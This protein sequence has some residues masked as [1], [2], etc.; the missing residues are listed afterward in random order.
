MNPPRPRPLPSPI[1]C[2]ATP[3]R[4]VWASLL[5]IL[6]CLVTT[7]VAR[8][9]QTGWEP[10]GSDGGIRYMIQL[11]ASQIELWARTGQLDCRIDPAVAGRVSE[12]QLLS[13]P[14]RAGQALPRQTPPGAM[15]R[16]LDGED[17][18]DRLSLKPP[19]AFNFPASGLDPASGQNGQATTTLGSAFN[20][21]GHQAAAAAAGQVD[22]AG[23]QLAGQVNQ[24]ISNAAGAASRSLYDPGT[25]VPP[26]A[27][28]TPAA[29]LTPGTAA[30]GFTPPRPSTD[31]AVGGGF[32]NDPQSRLAASTARP[33]TETRFPEEASATQGNGG[34]PPLGGFGVPLPGFDNPVTP[35]SSPPPATSRDFSDASDFASRQRYESGLSSATGRDAATPQDSNLTADEAAR[36]PPRGFSYDKYGWPIDRERFRLDRDGYRLDAD[37]QRLAQNDPRFVQPPRGAGYQPPPSRPD[38]SVD[39]RSDRSPQWPTEDDGRQDRRDEGRKYAARGYDDRGFDDRGYDD[40]VYEDRNYDDRGY[41]DREYDDRRRDDRGYDRRR[42]ERRYASAEPNY[43]SAADRLVD[44]RPQTPLLP[45]GSVGY[46]R[47]AGAG[48]VDYVNAGQPLPAARPPLIAAGSAAAPPPPT[49]TA[50][51]PPPSRTNPSTKTNPSFYSHQFLASVLIFSFVFNVYLLHLLKG[52]RDRYREMVSVRREATSA[53]PT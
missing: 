39:R 40:R 41:D 23:R 33:S 11:D 32:G 19:A 47:A 53:V 44:A 52:L 37:G 28:R 18:A 13:G 49:T 3:R 12:I 43:R 1:R 38:R 25:R 26:P 9:Q 16:Q 46:D 27:T 22:A 2:A 42:D 21:L 45:V 6:A 4:P 10:D 15:V 50:A 30:T 8:G 24:S 36:L 31:P 17:S 20:D 5:A 14:A 48:M 35:R 51:E 29:G 7:S 34:N